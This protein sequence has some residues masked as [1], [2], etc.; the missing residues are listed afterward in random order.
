[1][2]SSR[3]NVPTNPK[4][5]DRDV[6]NKL[7]LYG[8]FEAFSNGKLPTN[9]QIDVALTSFLNH[10]KLKNPNNQLSS[11]G[12]KILQDF[13]T[14]V[15]EAKRL[16]LLKNHDQALQEFIWHTTQLGQNGVSSAGTPNAPVSKDQANSDAQ[17]SLEG[18]KTLGQLIIT[19]G[20]FRKLLSDATLL[21]RDIAGDAA[22][23]AAGKVNPSQD[24]LRQIDDPAPDHEWHDA[25]NFSRDNLKNQMREKMDRNK[26]IS[27]DE[28]RDV[29]GN[30]TQAADPNNSRDP[31]EAA[32]RAAN[33]P[34]GASGVNGVEGLK[35]G[36]NDLTNRM[37][38]NIPEDKKDKARE[39]RERTQNYLKSKM[40]EERRDQ[41]IWRLKKMIIEIQGHRD[42][43]EAV[44]TLINLAE[45]YTGHGQNLANQSTSQVKNAHGDNHLKSAE[46]SLKVLIER[47]ANNTSADDLI[48]AINDIYT[49]AD[50]DPELKEWFRNMNQFIRRCLQQ[51]GYIMEP[52]STHEY[53]RLYDHGNFLLRNRYRDHTDRL[54]NEFQFMGEQFAADP[55]NKRFADA[56]DRLFKELGNDENGKPT[57]KKHLIKDITSVILP[58]IFESVRYVPIPRIEY[59]DRQFDA[60][61]ENLI[62]ESDNLM[63]NMFEIENDAHFRFGRKTATSK[64]SQ[65]VMVSASGIQCDLRDISYYV[66]R[67]QGFPSVTDLGIM[68]VFLGGEGFGFK[69]ALSTADKT[70]R[71]RFFKVDACK[72]NVSHLNIKLKKSKHKMLFGLFK[73]LLLKVLKP[74]VVKALE[75]QIRSTFNDFDAF[76]YRIYQEEQRIENELKNNPNPENAQNI[77]NR[78]YQA[79]QKELGIRKEQAKAKTADK[80]ANMAVTAEDSMFKDIKLPGGISTKATEFK[81][82]ARQ[83]EKWQSDV[84]SIGS[85]APTNRLP[86]PAQVTRKSPHA[87]RR[88]VK[89]RDTSSI[90]AHSRDSGYIPDGAPMYA[91]NT[92]Y[93]HGNPVDNNTVYRDGGVYNKAANPVLLNAGGNGN[94]N[95]N[96]KY[97]RYTTVPIGTA[98]GANAAPLGNTAHA[99]PNQNAYGIV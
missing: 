38:A 23:K 26:P 62:I 28:L 17:K 36:I 37:D 46:S 95:G 9:K 32:Q 43:N 20:Q 39:Y 51:Q 79:F 27:R 31:R 66:R 56:M 4:Q 7:R 44:D 52:A 24:E 82:Q 49:D 53:N 34:N 60:V 29:A 74:V 40:P 87:H 70:S 22:S 59:S 96:A 98:T 64:K 35:T 75:Q 45:T 21:L 33:A 10:N 55:D 68:D 42:Y 57:F 8:I 84:F 91:G 92:T 83:G 72:V 61:V 76:C 12:K 77:Y 71:N 54:V 25:P 19:N 30:A 2:S 67:K 88:R 6:E 65:K 15:E 63:P 80:H 93:T 13:R 41:T 94:G 1:M 81:Q 58:D 99:M 90:G 18:I 73:P 3:V 11:E 89:D 78:Y 14:V 47:F 5:R 50:R 97:D 16:I 86:S 69:L 85:A 48:D